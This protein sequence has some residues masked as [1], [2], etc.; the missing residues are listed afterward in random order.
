MVPV[1][2]AVAPLSAGTIT[3]AGVLTQKV[4]KPL[5]GSVTPSGVLTNIP[6]IALV[7]FKQEEWDRAFEQ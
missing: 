5:G 7:G 6:K 3:P 1:K 4:E 2:V